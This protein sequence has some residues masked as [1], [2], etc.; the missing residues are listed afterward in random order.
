M[1][2]HNQAY[3]DPPHLRGLQRFCYFCCM[4]DKQPHSTLEALLDRRD[5][6]ENDIRRLDKQI[7][8]LTDRVRSLRAQHAFLLNDIHAI[9]ISASNLPLPTNGR[10]NA[11]SA[12][13]LRVWAAL[14]RVLCQRS[15]ILGG[16]THVEATRIVQQA[17]PGC[18]EATVGSYLHQTQETWPNRQPY[19]N[20]AARAAGKGRPMSNRTTARFRKLYQALPPEIQQLADKNYQLFRQN[21]QHPSLHFKRIGRFWSAR[22]GAAHRALAV[23]TDDGFALGLD[24]RSRRIRSINQEMTCRSAVAQLLPKRPLSALSRCGRGG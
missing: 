24:R 11:R 12:A 13:T 14:H 22:V 17:I 3:W 10:P 7:A 8:T 5:L 16:L 15:P 2:F 21:P 20:L 18:K 4:S 23:D 9:Q 6:I 19:R 1:V